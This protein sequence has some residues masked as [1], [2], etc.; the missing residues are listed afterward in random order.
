MNTPIPM[1]LRAAAGLAAVAIDEARRLP[2]RLVS[3]PVLAVSTSLRASLTARQRYAM[4]AA[5]G[6]E[7]LAQIR[8]EPEG[9]PPWARFDEDTEPP[10][11]GDTDDSFGTEGTEGPSPLADEIEEIGDAADTG[12]VPDTGLVG[13]PG[14]PP[15]DQYDQ[16]SIAQLRARMRGLTPNQLED[17]IAWE[18]AHA[19]RPPYL[20]MLENRL[21]TVRE[22]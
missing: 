5:R 15:L 14:S 10:D 1:P 7:L 12:P 17:L 6:D 13:S 3:L 4:L 2:A 16:L 21:A 20:T 19:D 11:V 18:R 9:T 8:R 22:R